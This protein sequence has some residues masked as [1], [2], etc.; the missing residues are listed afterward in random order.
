MWRS[1]RLALIA[2]SMTLILPGCQ[3]T[4]P[5]P[6]TRHLPPAPSKLMRPVPVPKTYKGMD[7]RI[8]LR[9]YDTALVEANARLSASA[10]WYESVRR[11][12]AK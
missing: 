11:D 2:L 6:A 4:N 8:A 3:T 12:Y 1:C 9:R 5:G 7:A 10:G